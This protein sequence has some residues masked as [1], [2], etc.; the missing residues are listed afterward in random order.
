VFNR[1][2]RVRSVIKNDDPAAFYSASRSRE[3]DNDQLADLLEELRSHGVLI[4][5]GQIEDACEDG[6]FTEA[7]KLSIGR[8]F[9]LNRRLSRGESILDVF[10]RSEFA[11]FFA[12][13]TA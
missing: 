3:V 7:K 1:I 13:I 10:D 9:R 4:L 12:H 5:S 11:D 2:Q 6:T 8:V